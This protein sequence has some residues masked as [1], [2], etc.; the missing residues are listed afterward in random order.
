MKISQLTLMAVLALALGL[1][2]TAYAN[3]HGKDGMHCDRKHTMQDAD[4]DKDGALSH[5]EF[6]AHYQKMADDLFIKMDANK[7][8]KVDQTERD[9][10]KNKMGKKCNM[11]NHKIDESIK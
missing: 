11:K 9:G 1:S 4:T 8:G 10:I 7:D 6:N 5:D 2:Q 3:H